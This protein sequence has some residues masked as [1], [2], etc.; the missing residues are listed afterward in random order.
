[1]FLCLSGR[2]LVESQNCWVLSALFSYKSMQK[3]GIYILWLQVRP[4]FLS[5][6]GKHGD[7]SFRGNKPSLLWLSQPSPPWAR[8]SRQ[9]SL[10]HVFHESTSQRWSCI[11]GWSRQSDG[12]TQR[13]CPAQ[14]SPSIALHP[15]HPAP[16]KWLLTSGSGMS[17]LYRSAGPHGQARIW[18]E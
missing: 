10:H 6:V 4:R 8:K 17:R 13:R 14:W 1:M 12:A 9:Y 3:L 11:G 16:S 15:R 7:V 18:T 5:S 2:C